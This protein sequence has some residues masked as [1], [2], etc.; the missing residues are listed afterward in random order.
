MTAN[1]HGAGP[2]PAERASADQQALPL[3][4][5]TAT[6]IRPAW[7][8]VALM[9]LIT[10]IFTQTASSY[11][12]YVL[13]SV[14]L[15]CM[16]AIS[17]QLLQGTT[18]LFS[19]GNGAFLLVGGFTTVYVLRLGW[20]FPLDLVAATVT[21]AV[22]GLIVGLPTLKLRGLFLVLA[23]LSAY[24]IAVFVGNTYQQ[25]D[26][27]AQSA[28]FFVPVLFG[29]DPTNGGQYWAWLGVIIVSVCVLGASRLV[30]ERSG[31]ALRMIREHE[32]IAPALGI[33]V[34]RYKLTVFALTSAVISLQGALLAHLNG[35]VQTGDVPLSLA[36]T[37]VIMIVVG[38]L[39]SIAGAVI[40]ASIVVALPIVMPDI[41]SALKVDT[42]DPSLG[43][44]ISL[45][46][47]GVIVVLFVIFCPDGI[48]GAGRR[49]RDYLQTR[50][51][52]R[53]ATKRS[54]DA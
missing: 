2:R 22:A 17:L 30:R 15:T 16:G 35:N 47:Y 46:V 48:A 52:T 26:I 20:P 7:Y 49:L 50:W 42:T 34:A 6:K 5:A 53:L 45:I 40:G 23:T 8:G 21:G 13:D 3:L 18:G 28:G 41:I 9:L 4:V 31:R 27:S 10:L 32:T 43:A 51:V 14:L 37:Y 19:V 33:P 44:N 25:S 29:S 1:L 11:T 38:G 36:F 24:F 12:L 39:D 54:G